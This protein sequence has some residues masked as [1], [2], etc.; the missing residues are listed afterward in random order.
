MT[1]GTDCVLHKVDCWNVDD[2]VGKVGE[3]HISHTAIIRQ[4][5]TNELHL[6]YVCWWCE[7]WIWT[8]TK[9]WFN[10]WDKQ[11]HSNGTTNKK[12][13]NKEYNRPAKEIKNVIVFKH[14]AK[15]NEVFKNSESS[16]VF[17]SY[18]FFFAR[19]RS[20]SKQW[21]RMIIKIITHF[22]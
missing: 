12:K 3:L 10:N 18:F 5:Y 22:S 9:Q 13:L 17:F 16:I 7:K 20:I 8:K 2:S 11:I 15:W 1:V 6:N 14:V 21:V 4:N 19:N